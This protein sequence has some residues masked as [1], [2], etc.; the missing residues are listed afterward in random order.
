MKMKFKSTVKLPK[1]LLYKRFVGLEQSINLATIYKTSDNLLWTFDHE[2]L[3]F[4]KTAEAPKT[5]KI[6]IVSDNT[7]ILQYQNTY[8]KY[9]GLVWQTLTEL[10]ENITLL[11]A[12]FNNISRYQ[13]NKYYF[14]GSFDYMIKGSIE[15]T[16][17]QFLKGNI[18][19]LT[20]LNIKYFSDDIQLHEEDLVVIDKHLYSV[21]NP[22][23]V[24]KYNPKPYRVHFATL[25]SI[26]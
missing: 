23:T 21:E 12:T 22:E 1:G 5:S 6:V 25:N 2:T 18:I 7:T 26:L 13:T 10:P 11:N 17:T 3:T 14:V 9:N 16:E 20:S 15:G 4:S 24:V 8:F 19:P